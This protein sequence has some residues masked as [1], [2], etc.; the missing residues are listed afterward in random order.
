MLRYGVSLNRRSG[1]PAFRDGASPIPFRIAALLM[2][3]KP[4][5]RRFSASL[6][7]TVSLF[8]KDTVASNKIG[9]HI[10]QTNFIFCFK[11]TWLGTGISK[12]WN[13]RS[14]TAEA[15]H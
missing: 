6:G 8:L 11:G 10:P 14:L 1:P 4:A 9:S 15:P 12:V 2:G 3:V 13:K 7:Y 5:R